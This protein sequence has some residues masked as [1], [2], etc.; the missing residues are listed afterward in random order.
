[1]NKEELIKLLGKIFDDYF[2]LCNGLN[3]RTKI[4]KG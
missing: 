4:L 1:M 2:K 3:E